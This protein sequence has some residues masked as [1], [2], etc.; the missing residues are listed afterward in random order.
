MQRISPVIG[1][2]DS[3]FVLGNLVGSRG[4]WLPIEA[5]GFGQGRNRE[6]SFVMDE[7]RGFTFPV[8]IF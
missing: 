1:F 8:Y 5:N 7:M 4:R 3:E 2:L 6:R